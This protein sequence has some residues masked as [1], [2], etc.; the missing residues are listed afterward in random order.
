VGIGTVLFQ[1]PWAIFDILGAMRRYL[2]RKGVG[3]FDDLRGKVKLPGP[4]AIR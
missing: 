3:R 4:G 1:D 2:E